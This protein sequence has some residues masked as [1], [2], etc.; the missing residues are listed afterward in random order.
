MMDSAKRGLH[1]IATDLEEIE[2]EL[3]KA[4]AVLEAMSEPLEMT[5]EPGS[6]EAFHF[7][8]NQEHFN[9]LFATAFSLIFDAR[10][11]IMPLVDELIQ[12]RREEK[13]E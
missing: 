2:L 13:T 10:K 11:Q 5:I 12:R 4:A 8:A 6:P 9:L 1:D 3:H 7:F